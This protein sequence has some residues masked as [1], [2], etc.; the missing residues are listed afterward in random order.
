MRSPV[1][2]TDPATTTGRPAR[3]ATLSAFRAASS[4][5]FA[6]SSLELMQHKA[7]AI[8]SETVGQNDIR[9]GVGKSLM[10]AL[11][12]VRMLGVPEFWR[13][14]GSQT[15]GEQIGA[16]RAVRQQRP[17]F[18]QKGL[19]HVGFSGRTPPRLPLNLAPWRPGARLGGRSA[20]PRGSAHKFTPANDLNGLTPPLRNF[21]RTANFRVRPNERRVAPI[22]QTAFRSIVIARSA[23]ARR[24]DPGVAGAPRSPGFSPGPKARGSLAMTIASRPN[25]RSESQSHF[26]SGVDEAQNKRKREECFAKR[27]ERFRNGVV[28]H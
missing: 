17:A 13:I 6:R 7:A 25:E 27:N 12:P 21:H 19:Q 4:I 11:D 9:T 3:S 23:P 16:G 26:V 5:E 8:G 24:S 18:G 2:P 1:G 22:E 14:A 28:S 10:Q 20:R 15:H